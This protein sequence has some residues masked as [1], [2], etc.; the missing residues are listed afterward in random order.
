M[1]LQDSFDAFS[2][3]IT[4]L[5]GAVRTI[6]DKVKS[7]SDDLASHF[8]G[9]SLVFNTNDNTL[10][11]TK[12]DGTAQ[13]IDLSK[14]LDNNISALA[15]AT[16]DSANKQLVFTREDGTTFNVSTAVFFDDTNLVVS[17]AGKSGTVTLDK[18]DVGLGNVDNTADANKA[19][20][21][22]TKL[23]ATCNINGV[24]FDGS[25]AITVAD[26]TKL[27]LAGGTMTGGLTVKSLI[28]TH[29]GL[30]QPTPVAEVEVTVDLSLGN[31]F[32]FATALTKALTLKFTNVP[33]CGVFSVTVP[34]GSTAYAVTLGTGGTHHAA[35]G[36]S[37]LTLTASSKDK[38]VCEVRNG[39]FE[40]SIIKDI[41]A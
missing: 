18:T 27:P 14:Y 8:H 19:V 40:W 41:K 6:A 35:G 25:A 37:K 16:Y 30:V 12:T 22:A 9:D 3:G 1:S 13:V 15:G 11:Y 31:S 17:V 20:L 23:A 10:T 28:E 33:A 2:T 39:T 4:N 24:P 38:L 21:S 5:S 29:I 7:T 34:S 26:V 36:L 32:G